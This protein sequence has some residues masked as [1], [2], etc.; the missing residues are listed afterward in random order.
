[1]CG[2]AGSWQRDG[3]VDPAAAARIVAAMARSLAH[4]GPDRAGIWV[5]AEAG[6]AFAALPARTEPQVRL[7]PDRGSSRRPSTAGTWVI[8]WPSAN[9]T[10][11]VRCGRD[12]CPPG[13]RSVTWTWSEADVIGPIRVPRCPTSTLGS[14]CSAK[15]VLTPS[16]PPAPITSI[17]PPGPTHTVALPTD[18]ESLPTMSRCALPVALPGSTRYLPSIVPESAR[19]S[20]L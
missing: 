7:T 15:I 4:R 3:A 11:A 14:Q 18:A 16:S 20:L 1:M 2:I 17:E 10:S 9:T 13:P 5:D 19:P 8:T 6:I 12:V